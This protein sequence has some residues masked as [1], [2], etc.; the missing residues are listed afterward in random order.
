MRL[1]CSNCGAEYEV[2]DDVVPQAGRDVQCSNC[3]HI[4]FQ[5]P[6]GSET[7]QEPFLTDQL[8]EDD[9]F[10]DPP[11]IDLS[12][13]DPADPSAEPATTPCAELSGQ[14]A[15]EF[16]DS[17]AQDAPQPEQRPLPPRPAVDKTVASILREEAAREARLRE[18]DGDPLAIQT[19]MGLDNLPPSQAADPDAT[20]SRKGV[21]PDIEEINS[22]LHSSDDS[23]PM[24]D[25]VAAPPHKRSGG[26]MRGFSVALI[27]GAAL[28]LIYLNAPGIAK[29]VP[30][31]DP[32]LSA[33]VALVDQARVW[34]DTTAGA[35]LPKP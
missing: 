20:A 12:M 16:E 15:Q 8:A 33:Y 24:T 27:I 32:T 30:Q 14:P 4:W 31:A 3:G 21:L 19:D 28:V 26:F 29:T 23:A 35:Y 34:L 25:A 11:E 17:F 5:H 22:T 1:S 10:E 6:A 18:Q 2:P 7:E 9:A 13:D